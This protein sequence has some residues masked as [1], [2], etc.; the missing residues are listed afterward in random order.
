[1]QDNI[2]HPQY[3]LVL[4]NQFT[5]ILLKESGSSKLAQTHWSKGCVVLVRIEAENGKIHILKHSIVI[6]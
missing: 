4:R 1:M 6:K 2:R 3:C 5:G